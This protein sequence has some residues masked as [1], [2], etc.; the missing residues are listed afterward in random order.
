MENQQTKH[1]KENIIRMVFKS[2]YTYCFLTGLCIWLIFIVDFLGGYRGFHLS[3][4]LF[5]AILIP[6]LFAAIFTLIVLVRAIWSIIRLRSIV[7]SIIIILAT[8]GF[9]LTPRIFFNEDA[10]LLGF[11]YRVQRLSS[12]QELREIA[13]KA[14]ELLIE[15]RWLPGPGK[16]L[17][18]EEVHAELWE[19]MPKSKIIS[20]NTNFVVI[21]V[22]DNYD[23]NLSWGGALVGHWGIRIA[24]GNVEQSKYDAAYIMLEKDIAVYKSMH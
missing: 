1:N 18:E 22:D 20:G 10:Y 16:N 11:K 7:R 19:K 12:S 3:V 15:Q 5:P 23:V 14:R 2:Q 17:W 4:S 9:W 24:E 6:F 8:L 13:D 21:S